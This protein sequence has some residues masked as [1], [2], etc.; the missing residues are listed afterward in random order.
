MDRC[1]VP[2]PHGVGKPIWIGPTGGSDG[3]AQ[4]VAQ[5]VVARFRLDRHELVL[6]LWFQDGS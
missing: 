3:F 4:C 1:F 6:M 5:E 2:D